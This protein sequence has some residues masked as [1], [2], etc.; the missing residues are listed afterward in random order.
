MSPATSAPKR[1]KLTESRLLFP[2]LAL[3]IILVFD[4]FYVPGFFTITSRD[5]NLYGNLIDILRNG[6][7]VMLLAIGMTFVI[8][9]GGVDLSVGAVMAIAAS[10]AAVMIN[11]DVVGT[12]IGAVDTNPNLTSSP[13]WLVFLVTL[14]V[15][16]ICG[17]WNGLLIAYG[18]IQAIM[19][20]LV[21]MIAGRGIAQLITNGV[22]IQIFYEPYKYIGTE[23]KILPVSLYIVAAVYVVAWLL[24]R[25]TAIGLFVESVGINSTSSYFSGID[26]KKIKL[27]AYAFCG[28]CAGI[29]GIVYSSNI[30]T[31]DA[32]NTG[33]G[34]ELD[35]I[36]AVAI[37]G[38]LTTGGRFSLAASLVGALVMQATTTSILAIGVPAFAVQAIKGA[39]VVLVLLLYSNQLRV[40]LRKLTSHWSA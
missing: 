28:F 1:K 4:F 21:L 17:L 27:L 10:V 29:A 3:G 39:V 36:L 2:I 33:L 5:G 38:T 23:W 32:N 7:T 40:L 9:T 24:T 30:A 18:K 19:A 11:P 25:R 26:E 16:T 6:S 8:A 34:Y 35:A 15:S 31:S 20:T 37:G 14:V 22:R 12:S 13:L